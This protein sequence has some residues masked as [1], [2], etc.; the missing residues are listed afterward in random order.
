VIYTDINSLISGLLK[1]V[2]KF[3]VQFFERDRYWYSRWSGAVSSLYP[4]IYFMDSCAPLTLLE[5]ASAE[6]S[7]SVFYTLVIVLL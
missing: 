2:T 4:A 5:G 1:N 7:N 3:F 6:V